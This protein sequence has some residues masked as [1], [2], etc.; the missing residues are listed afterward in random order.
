[1]D[2]SFTIPL[3][4]ALATYSVILAIEEAAMKHNNKSTDFRLWAEVGNVVEPTKIPEPWTQA[5]DSNSA[6]IVVFLKHFDAELQTLRGVDHLY[7]RKNDKV[8][9]LLPAIQAQ[10][11]WPSSQ[12]I[13]LYE[14]CV[15]KPRTL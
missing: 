7:Q 4:V 8:A 11:G 1:M 5:R 6:W 15:H 2:S 14:V 3:F 9:E 13:K 12:P 10:M